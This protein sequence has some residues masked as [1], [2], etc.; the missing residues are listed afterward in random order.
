MYFKKEK[1]WQNFP[2]DIIAENPEDAAFLY[3]FLK[4]AQIS[5]MDLDTFEILDIQ[6][7]RLIKKRHKIAA[8][9]KFHPSEMSFIFPVNKN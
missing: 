9:L 3:T 4:N 1:Y 8:M 6:K 7:Y 5:Q 2:H